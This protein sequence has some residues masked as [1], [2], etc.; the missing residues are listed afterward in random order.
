MSVLLRWGSLGP[1]A[2]AVALACAAS[3]VPG[4]PGASLPL[5]PPS[6]PSGV[7][8]RALPP[9][10]VGAP[11]RFVVGNGLERSLFTEDQKS[12]CSILI[13]EREQGSGWEPIQGC[14][15]E[16]KPAVM[17]LR[18]GESREGAID[19]WSTHFDRPPGSSSPAFGAGRYRLRLTYRL[20]QLP[21]GEEPHAVASAPFRIGS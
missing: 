17:E 2:A 14:N 19:P 20:A 6:G 13:L 16:R 5:T 8:V 3:P 1:L 21:E 9:I 10:A 12:G 11:V 7:E 15:L 18:P 4:N